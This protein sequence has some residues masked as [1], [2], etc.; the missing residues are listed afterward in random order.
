[1]GRIDATVR[2]EPLYFKKYLKRYEINRRIK[3]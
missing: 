1:L 2:N 3:L